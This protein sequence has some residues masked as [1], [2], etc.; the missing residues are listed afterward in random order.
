[1]DEP[2]IPALARLTREQLYNR[3]W[4]TPISQLAEEFGVSGRGLKKICERHDIPVPYR[5]YWAK[6]AAGKPVVKYRLS[7]AKVPPDREVTIRRTPP[8]HTDTSRVSV[9]PADLTVPEEI[10]RPH[11]LVREWIAEDRRA[12]KKRERHV[13]SWLTRYLP[14]PFTQAADRRYRILD[15]LFKRFERV[16]L[17]VELG[18]RRSICVHDGEANIVIA[19]REKKKKGVRPLDD[20][21]RSI[22]ASSGKTE[23][24]V[25]VGTGALVFEVKFGMPNRFEH[26]WADSARQSLEEQVGKI[27]GTIEAAFPVIHDER[28]C[29]EE[30]WR[31]RE[32]EEAKQREIESARRLDNNRWRR[33]KELSR[34]LEDLDAAE[35]MID[36]LAQR[37]GN[38]AAG[39]VAWARTRL[40]SE[41][42]ALTDPQTIASEIGRIHEWTY[43]G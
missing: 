36:A 12:R 14:E 38:D 9:D 8:L 25:M 43:R 28:R 4:E 18:E 10:S 11:R 20:W 35:R 7:K 30:A 31:L 39:V 21:E 17:K 33:F 40:E 29:A 3:V 42:E 2:S 26:T 13:E 19:I 34:Q 1:M 16:G 41:R 6:K 27:A 23:C 24:E 15:A 22:W 32:I 5:G 37:E